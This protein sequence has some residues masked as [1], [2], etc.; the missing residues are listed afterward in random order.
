GSLAQPR[1]PAAS[2]KRLRP[3]GP[4]RA[5]QI[6]DAPTPAAIAVPYGYAADGDTIT[7]AETVLPSVA[8]KVT[9]V[10]TGTDAALAE[11]LALVCPAGT[12]TDGG[13]PTVFGLEL[14]S[15]TV[16]PPAGAGLATFT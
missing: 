5:H 1:N 12:T 13:T 3:K 10:G 14:V 7:E 9:L 11:M 16:A 8:V 15:V 2:S 6:S 4:N